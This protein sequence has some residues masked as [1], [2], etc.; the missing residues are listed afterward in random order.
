MLKSMIVKTTSADLLVTILV[1]GCKCKM[2]TRRG[3]GLQTS[4]D[5]MM[6]AEYARCLKMRL[7]RLVSNAEDSTFAS[8]Y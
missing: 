6:S 2:C 1:Y 5:Q 4:K 7:S 3:Q 8:D